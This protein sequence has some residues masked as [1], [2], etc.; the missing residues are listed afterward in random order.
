MNK[1]LGMTVKRWLLYPVHYSFYGLSLRDF[2]EVSSL[3]ETKET[4]E[5]TF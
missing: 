1:T 5:A 3:D 4:R 2:W